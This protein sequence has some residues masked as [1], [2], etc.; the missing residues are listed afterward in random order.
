MMKKTINITTLAFIFAIIGIS[1]GSCKK[2]EIPDLVGTW[3]VHSYTEDRLVDTDSVRLSIPTGDFEIIFYQ[4]ETGA[5]PYVDQTVDWDYFNNEE[6]I[7]IVRTKPNGTFFATYFSVEI[8]NTDYK[9][10]FFGPFE[11]EL[12]QAAGLESYNITF[13]ELTR[14]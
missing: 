14:K 13:W 7:T 8:D 4:D 3:M 10:W 2:E 9:K 12:A 11:K 5:I 6:E 1:I